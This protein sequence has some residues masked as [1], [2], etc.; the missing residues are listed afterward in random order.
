[1]GKEFFNLDRGCDIPDRVRFRSFE[2]TV[3]GKETPDGS[4]SDQIDGTAAEERYL[5]VPE[6]AEYLQVSCNTVYKM[7]RV[8]QIPAVRVGRLLR[9]SRAELDEALRNAN[10]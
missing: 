6:V 4:A 1:M 8:G 2:Q 7:I 5:G 3:T 10:A 9:V